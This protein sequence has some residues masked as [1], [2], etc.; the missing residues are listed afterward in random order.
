MMC[1]SPFW[2]LSFHTLDNALWCTK[3]F[4]FYKVPF[5]CFFVAFT[6][7]FKSMAKS[8]AIKIYSSKKFIIL[9]LTPR[10]LTHLEFIFVYGVR[11]S[12]YSFF[13]TWLSR[14]PSAVCCR[15]F[16]PIDWP[17]RPAQDHSAIDVGVGSWTH[18]CSVVSGAL[19]FPMSE[20]LPPWFTLSLGP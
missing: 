12:S 2:G 6:F 13:C 4:N 11:C 3:G 10:S 14:C 20:F 16:F 17:W 5:V 18:F 15:N 8:K 7:G 19:Q 9:T 1:R